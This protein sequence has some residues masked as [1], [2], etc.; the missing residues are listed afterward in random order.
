M[1]KILITLVLSLSITAIFA[2]VPEKVKIKF[3]E[4]Y[5]DYNA[6]TWTV[7]DDNEYAVTFVDRNKAENY[8]VYDMN[9]NIVSADMVTVEYPAEIKTYYVK[10]YPDQK[11][12]HVWVAT[13]ANG[14]KTYYVRDH[15]YRIWFDKTG[16]FVKKQAQKVK[17]EY[18]E[19]KKK[20]KDGDHDD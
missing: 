7:V 18:K 1:K 15:E 14:N 8:I 16:H 20:I 3:K 10:N 11:D 12:Y 17:Q 5:P 13:D 2:Q 19:E 6:V 9:G 4:K